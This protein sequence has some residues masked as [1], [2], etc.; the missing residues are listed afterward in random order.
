MNTLSK[1]LLSVVVTCA[2]ALIT[3][4][5]STAFAA[6]DVKSKTVF[7][8]GNAHID[9]AWNWRYAETIQEV[10]TT[11]T[12][13][14][15]LMDANPSYHF[16]Q[17]A[18]QYYEWAKEYYPELIPRINA[19]IKNGQW[20]IV[21][22]Q[23][24]EPDLNTP[25][26]ESLVRQSLYAQKY[27]QKNFNVTPKVGWVP[28]VFGFT[29]NMPQIL[30]K[31]GM[32]YFVT[33]KLN[34]NDTNKFPYEIFN[35]EGADGSKLLTYKPTNDYSLSGGGLNPENFN[36][37]MVKPAALGLD[38]AIALYGSGDHG[39]GP[40]PAD[41]SKLNTINLD[42]NA[43]AVK[44]E[45]AIDAFNTIQANVKDKAVTLPEV[46]DELY[47]EKHRGTATS[48][49]PMKKYDRLSEIKAEE[50]EK[51]SSVATILGS[52]SYPTGKINAAWAKTNLNQ[53]HDV[54]PGSAI[55][56][57]YDDAFNDAEIALNELNS[58]STNA[59]NGIDDRINT[60]GKG[61]AIV[62]QNTLS[63]D[64]TTIAQSVVDLSGKD[65]V[66]G[67][68]DP[69][70]KEVSSQI[71][72]RVG[73]KVTVEY[74]AT[75]P[76]MGYAVYRAVETKK[77][78][79]NTSLVVDQKNKTIENKFLK[80]VIDGVTGNIASIHDKINNKEV[81]EK[82]KEGNVL[83]ILEDTPKDWDAW[84]VDGDDMKATPTELNS[85][86]SVK[87]VENGPLKATYRIQKSYGSS[88]ISQ[89]ITLSADS[90]K[91]DVKL[92]TDWNETQKMLK[93][94]FPM[95]VSNDKATYEIGYA[96]IDRT[97]DINTSKFE[98]N[99]H[100]WADLTA[101]DKSYGVSILND[102]KYGWNTFGNVMRLTLIKSAADR[103]GNKDRGHQE[104]SYAIAPH[105]GDWKAAD[106]VLKGYNF[107][108]PLIS[109]TVKSHKGDLDNKGTFGKVTSKDNNVIMTVL[110]KAEDSNNYIVRM[111]ESEGKDGSTATVNL[112]SNIADV[113]EVNLIENPV[114]NAVK[115]K[116]TG[117]TFATT[118]NKYEI[119][120]FLVKFNN[121][122]IFKD[123]KPTTTTVDLS[124]AYNLD[125]ISTDANRADGD[126]TGTGE[127]FSAELMPATVVSEGVKFNMGPKADGKANIVKANG[128]KIKVA[129]GK[130]K[131]LYILA[132][133]TSG[134]NSGDVLVNYKG[135][136]S[137]TKGFNFAGW[138]DTVGDNLKTYVKS[139]IG[140]NLSH[141]HTPKG[142]TYDIDNN[143]F[144]YKMELDSSKSVES[145]TLPKAEGMK[146]A[147]MSF[148][149]G[150]NTNNIDTQAPSVVK[151]LAITTLSKYYSPYV[152]L[153]WDISKDNVGV[154]DYI[155]YR[156]TK[157]DLSDLKVLARSE[158]NTYKDTD[159]NSNNSFYYVVKAEDAEGNIGYASDVKNTYAG[160]NIAI[161]KV[162]TSDSSA[163]DNESPQMAVD[164]NMATKWCANTKAPHWLMLDLGSVKKIDG[165]KIF[166]AS[167]GGEDANWNTKDYTISVSDDNKTWSTP[168]IVNGNTKGITEDL[169]KTSGR[170]VKLN[171]TVPTNTTN[172]GVRIY[173]LQVY[174]DDANF[175]MQVPTTAPVIKAIT[176]HNLTAEVAFDN[177]PDADRYILKYGTEPGKYD[178][179]ITDLYGGPVIIDPVTP[180]TTYYFTVT[181]V[182]VLG[183]GT[184]SV[185]K[186]IKIITP[187]LKNID[188]SSNYNLDGIA[189]LTRNV[190]DGNFDGGGGIF[191]ADVM[192]QSF[193]VQNFSFTL[194]SMKDGDKN[195]LKCD[196][197]TIVLPQEK[198]TDLYLLESAT[199]GKQTGNFTVNYVDGT[200]EVKS[201]SMSDWCSTTVASPESF[202]LKMDHRIYGGGAQDLGVNL[203]LNSIKIDG[204][205]VV[206]SI[207]TPNNE[208]M[209]IFAL[210]MLN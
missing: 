137:T 167:A 172:T 96:A 151:N 126:L 87:L 186:S 192:P 39:G 86:I 208:D 43:P 9:A 158:T 119:K 153:S 180:G 207:T 59:I 105:A 24:I 148:V 85:A 135:N 183:Q 15:D 97:T 118:L 67:I 89:D 124:K 65:K 70:G 10:K 92:S 163:S 122:A 57:V 164:G 160:A 29:Y 198:T 30:K 18:S 146:I 106:T 210:T 185:E 134:L 175:P 91:V 138:L 8:L 72:S 2:V 173:E 76:A 121:N 123:Q 120:T 83:Q 202:A 40:I 81:F 23:V 203:Y 112:P 42:P 130:H 171:V 109:Q 190:K 176:Q 7:S 204:T 159:M 6:T 55:T 4:P 131:M 201:V 165:F 133:S 150:I 101:T 56:P 107:N 17:S 154:T 52:A 79:T 170:Y 129:S 143:L 139:T 155:I 111:Y 142:N 206:K 75:V 41:I 12:R 177:T 20:E 161:G 84:D 50:T 195:V 38:Y 182:N 199:N 14:L 28:D 69:K 88:Q 128:Q 157:K 166:H 193:K 19:K 104:M 156:A 45:S 209:K 16:S 145:V 117:K 77:P 34:W 144:V 82:G 110:K 95:S 22:G 200:S 100:K 184:P 63:W 197:S 205:K 5:A 58:S 149:D 127:T 115:P 60:S 66:V 196:G 108:Y 141:T 36:S 48:A 102:C 147:A 132:A 99:G 98:V 174:G 194:G 64:R 168:V 78:A 37:M 32:D 169:V 61:T 90:N 191:D 113:T 33:T 25:S 31:S 46:N 47:L 181:P 27:F 114:A 116:F 103:G 35:W 178:K 74:T 93:V 187:T 26:G 136:K 62:L 54:L 188:M 94:A 53:F 140:I 44:M 1:R 11:F 125:G 3:I 68:L 80:V 189:S 49:A 21:G 13:A 51:L 162:A 73:D 71:V 152:N 179:T